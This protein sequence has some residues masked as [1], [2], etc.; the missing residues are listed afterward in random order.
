[1]AARVGPGA[2]QPAAPSTAG[3][4]NAVPGQAAQVLAQL[5]LVKPG[6]SAVQITKNLVSA[7]A[8]RGFG[9]G[10]L[11]G[12][13]GEKL[14]AALAQFQK[15]NGLPVTG[16]LDGQTAKLLQQLGLLPRNVRNSAGVV[17]V[18]DGFEGAAKAQ[19][20]AKSADAGGAGAAKGG[21][22]PQNLQQ[23]LSSLVKAAS[24]GS[25][26]A[27]E[28]LGGLLGLGG[29]QGGVAEG[30]AQPQAQP[31]GAAEAAVAAAGGKAADGDAAQVR[32]D[33]TQLGKDTAGSASK[34]KGDEKTRGKKGL[35]DAKERGVEDEGDDEEGQGKDGDQGSSKGDGSGG[36][37]EDGA[38]DTGAEQGDEDGSEKWSGNASSGDDD[39]DK[40]RGHAQ[41]PDD[42]QVK[43][44]YYRIPPIAEQWRRALDLVRRDETASTR[45]TTYTW[46]FVVYRPDV[47]GPGQQAEELLHL[48]VKEATAFDRAWGRAVDALDTLVRELDGPDAD[49]PIKED[50]LRA[51]RRA[52][53]S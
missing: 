23:L 41:L 43:P 27:M 47:Y 28:F 3:N 7:L 49:A 17:N 50:L 4:P 48:V 51:I 5:G 33:G 52:R 30:G 9:G 31:Q 44:G 36:G 16:Q 8:A 25:Q 26:K 18:K 10:A 19:A 42:W 53:V 32:G 12:L 45:T 2:G 39:R 29:G 1:M 34:T 6:M 13:L 38:H 46:D 40:Q 15:A 24:E 11:G 37:A 20:Q 21:E 22:Q 35:K 14:S